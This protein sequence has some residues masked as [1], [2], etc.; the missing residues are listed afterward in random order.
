MSN[1]NSILSGPILMRSAYFRRRMAIPFHQD[2][3]N[4][5]LEIV[6]RIANR[7]PE[8]EVDIVFSVR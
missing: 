2:I 7:F 6:L 4:V 1:S 8:T 3:A 5:I